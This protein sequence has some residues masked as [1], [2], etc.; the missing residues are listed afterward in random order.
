LSRPDG[1]QRPPLPLRPCR[2]WAGCAG[3]GGGAG[4]GGG[5]ERVRALRMWSATTATTATTAIARGP[6]SLVRTLASRI[7]S[8]STW[9]GLASPLARRP[10]LHPDRRERRPRSARY[11]RLGSRP[12]HCSTQNGI[13]K[14]F[15]MQ[16]TSVG[17]SAD[18]CD[19]CRLVSPLSRDEVSHLVSTATTTT[20]S[21]KASS[22]W[23]ASST[24]TTFSVDTCPSR[25]YRA[26]SDSADDVSRR[27]RPIG[28]IR[29]SGW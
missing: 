28:C 15:S 10:A 21:S 9:C 23:T 19:G 6:L 7:W 18:V 16:S 25:R 22:S 27:P 29:G 8:T 13:W 3:P 4:Q 12:P 17:L 20:N 2:S 11:R 24:S 26:L 14:I 1:R 5:G